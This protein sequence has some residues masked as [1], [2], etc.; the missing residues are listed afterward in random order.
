M[1][2][3]RRARV[4]PTPDV[5]DVAAPPAPS[6]DLAEV[7]DVELA[8]LPEKYRT[9]VV[10]CDLEGEPQ[11]AVAARLRV[12]VGTVYSRLAT[13]RKLL[14]ERLRS[15]GLAAAGLAVLSGSTTQAA[16]P[17]ELATSALRVSTGS[18]SPSAAVADLVRGVFRTMLLK[19]LK[20]VSACAL[21]L[22]LGAAGLLCACGSSEVVA[23][24][25]ANSPVPGVR[26][27]AA[28]VPPDRGKLFLWRAENFAVMTT[29]GKVLTNLQ[30]EKR[31]WGSWLS[32]DGTK[33]V[34]Q[35]LNRGLLIQAVDGKE[36][37]KELDLDGIRGCWS[38]DGKQFLAVRWPKEG[39][40]TWQFYHVLIDVE[41][42]VQTPL[43]LPAGIR[44]LDWSRDR[45]TFVVE[46]VNPAVKSLIG[47]ISPA[48]ENLRILGTLKDRYCEV[49]AR[50]S[51]DGTKILLIDHDPAR[52]RAHHWLMS[53]RLYLFDVA[54]NKFEPLPG[55]PEDGYAAGIAWS[56][57]GKRIAY[58][59]QKL[60]DELLKKDKFS[61]EDGETPTDG[62]MA[63]AEADGKNPK[64]VSSTRWRFGS[65][66][67]PVI[68]YVD[69]R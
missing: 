58:T 17:G 43:K 41:T 63:I 50:L 53:R 14:A 18:E 12:P 2:A 23:S 26:P 48:G 51:P 5:P 25:P 24:E 30:L 40:G 6:P 64:T 11:P 21:M 42:G 66:N 15:R 57:D 13:A 33:V 62:F 22:A 65:P 67:S 61:A 68:G 69:W 54:A 19:K 31:S 9:L 45:K 37:P 1:T 16:V 56:P 10:L 29:D 3:R 35:V 60:D 4:Q 32:P 38:P 34:Y 59:W 28:P 39:D 36:E 55:F 44:V 27:R 7:I 49:V 8:R 52:K 46:V 20:L 47:L